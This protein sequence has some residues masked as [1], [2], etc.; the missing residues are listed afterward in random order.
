MLKEVS[1]AKVCELFIA[2]WP[3]PPR[4]IRGLQRVYSRVK[5]QIKAVPR[6]ILMELFE[7]EL[8]DTENDWVRE[9]HRYLGRSIGELPFIV[10]L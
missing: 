7:E 9:E 5:L 2:R 3:E 10:L 6:E 4:G 1:W 8:A